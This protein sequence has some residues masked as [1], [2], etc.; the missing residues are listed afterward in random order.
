MGTQVSF[1]ERNLWC[2]H[3]FGTGNNIAK[4]AERHT[5]KWKQYLLNWEYIIMKFGS[6]CFGLVLP[7]NGK[8]KYF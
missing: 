7:T 6:H 4:H 5:C 8:A 1:S 3:R 2:A